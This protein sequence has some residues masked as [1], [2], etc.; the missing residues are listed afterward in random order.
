MR[1]WQEGEW[2]AV[3]KQYPQELASLGILGL[4]YVKIQTIISDRH[5]QSAIK[6]RINIGSSLFS[7]D[8]NRIT[9]A[10]KFVPRYNFVC[11][12]VGLIIRLIGYNKVAVACL[13]GEV[14]SFGKCKKIDGIIVGIIT[15][16]MRHYKIWCD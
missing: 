2:Q 13:T 4:L 6:S 12:F 3:K 15:A 5:K 10:G 1:D 11:T 8:N 9:L 7:V 16:F 14:D